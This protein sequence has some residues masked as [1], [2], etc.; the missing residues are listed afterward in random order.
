MASL[1]S[2]VAALNIV[3]TNDD[4]L[5]QQTSRSCTVHCLQRDTMLF[6]PRPTRAKVVR[7]V[8]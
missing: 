7:L 1:A 2:Q 5:R 4:D 8:K 6:Y 3:L